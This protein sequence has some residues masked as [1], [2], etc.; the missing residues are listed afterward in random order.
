[1]GARKIN[2]KKRRTIG[3]EKGRG[4][5]REKGRER[6]I[7]GVEKKERREE[8][9]GRRRKNSGGGEGGKKKRVKK[10]R[11]FHDFFNLSTALE[12]NPLKI[13]I[14]ALKFDCS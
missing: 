11:T 4:R 9:E 5:R 8:R 3:R 13:A 10:G 14:K 12:F 2:A 7:F 1:M 6:G